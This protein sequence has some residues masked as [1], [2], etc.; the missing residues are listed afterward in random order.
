MYGRR[1]LAAENIFLLKS[2]L[3]SYSW[4]TYLS[5]THRAQQLP[6]VMEQGAHHS[7][8]VLPSSEI[9]KTKYFR[10]SLTDE[11]S[12]LR[13]TWDWLETDL[14]PTWGQ[15]ETDLRKKDEDWEL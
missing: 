8:G 7:L 11:G 12:K 13:E 1:M 3:A 9:N 2:L 14:R 10:L 15:P 5:V 6:H 4:L